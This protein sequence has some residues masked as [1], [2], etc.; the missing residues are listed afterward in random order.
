MV[1]FLSKRYILNIVS[2]LLYLSL[3]LLHIYCTQT[4]NNPVLAM[5]KQAMLKQAI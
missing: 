4:L 5:L 3:V 2:T 1:T